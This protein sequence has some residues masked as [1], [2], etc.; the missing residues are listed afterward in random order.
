MQDLIDYVGSFFGCMY[1]DTI[2][3][4][5]SCI[6]TIYEMMSD[7]LLMVLEQLMLLA[8]H[9][10]NYASG[11]NSPFDLQSYVDGLPSQVLNMIGLIGLDVALSMIVASILIRFSLQLIPFVRLGS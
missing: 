1:N 9:M 11:S 6:L 4:F 10:L 3:F 2:V 8:L 5:Q 7:V